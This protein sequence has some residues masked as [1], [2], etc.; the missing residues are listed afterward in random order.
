MLQK[1]RS[2]LGLSS[3]ALRYLAI[4]LMLLDH[5]WLGLR[6]P[7]AFWM[8]CLGRLAFPLFAFLIAEGF[9]HTSDRK[10]YALRLFLCGLITEIP[11]DVFVSSALFSM[12]SQNV[13]FTLLFGLL[14]LWMFQWAREQGSVKHHILACMGFA[15]LFVLATRSSTSYGGLGMTM[16]VMFGLLRGV[17]G[18]LLWELLCLALLNY[19]IPGRQIRLGSVMFSIQNLGTLAIV[20][21]ALYN[22]Q[23]GAKN[24]FLQLGCYL[25]YPVH[26][27]LLAVLRYL[28]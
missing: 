11:Y 20:P 12:R 26:M 25:F 18:A 1:I 21:I 2:K 9:Y 27:G 10:R 17:K 7:H 22:G 4:A 28:L 19:L 24:R 15:A 14:A 8:T 5:I 16:V 23:R 3:A 6:P 13:L